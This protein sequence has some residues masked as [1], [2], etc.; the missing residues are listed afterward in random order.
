M[1]ATTKRLSTQAQSGAGESSF[2]EGEGPLIDF[3]NEPDL[4]DLMGLAELF[5]LIFFVMG[6]LF[7]ECPAM[8]WGY[9]WTGPVLFLGL[10]TTYWRGGVDTPNLHPRCVL[11]MVFWF[12]FVLCGIGCIAMWV[13]GFYN[14]WEGT[15]EKADDLMYMGWAPT[16]ATMLTM[17]TI[18]TY[19]HG[20]T[21]R[22][23]IGKLLW[24]G[25]ILLDIF[26]VP[27]EYM[28]WHRKFA[29]NW[30]IEYEINEDIF[31]LF[32]M[33]SVIGVLLVIIAEGM[34]MVEEAPAEPEI[35]EM[36][37]PMMAAQ[38]YE[39]V[40]IVADDDKKANKG[41]DVKASDSHRVGAKLKYPF[42]PF[43]FM[44]I[45]LLNKKEI[46]EKEAQKELGKGF[47]GR[48]AAKAA[49]A[50]TSDETV[51]K[52]FADGLEKEM[53]SMMKQFGVNMTL[54]R[55]YSK[56]PLLTFKFTMNEVE[57][58]TL[59]SQ[60]SQ[61]MVKHYDNLMLALDAFDASEEKVAVVDAIWEE[62]KLNLKK[63]MQKTLPEEMERDAGVKIAMFVTE[64]HE[65]ADWFYDYTQQTEAAMTKGAANNNKKH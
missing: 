51:C 53:P 50:A 47:M 7:E 40:Q 14:C 65:Q 1:P 55:C 31:G 43:F 4:N 23:L 26:C 44:N 27:W 34:E 18:T 30:G 21:F 64:A 15:M 54:K 2:P 48:M 49:N 42:T 13:W 22:H 52:E 35:E 41:G 56:G 38:Q 61:E 58:R 63:E 24:S 57:P 19:A 36:I 33:F 6:V 32:E 28:T 10:W 29:K 39:P 17:L 37:S 25:V 11:G 3:P 62:G 46:V 59:L 8:K 20:H 45:V 60:D 9:H 16:C 12:F 5:G